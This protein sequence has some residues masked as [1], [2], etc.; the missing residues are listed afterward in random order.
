MLRIVTDT[1]SRIPR[2]DW[3]PVVRKLC[4]TYWRNA[5]G[6]KGEERLNLHLEPLVLDL[7]R[8]QLLSEAVEALLIGGLSPGFS[9]QHGTVGIHL[10]SMDQPEPTAILLM[11]DDGWDMQGEP[12][13]PLITIARQN[14]EK[15]G[16]CL[17]WQPARGAVWRMYIPINNR[18]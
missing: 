10:W 7:D 1:G 15:A 2:L 17:E 14:A 3:A 5:G 8:I 4:E 11:A 13:T 6:A 12:S 18:E 9:P 16:C